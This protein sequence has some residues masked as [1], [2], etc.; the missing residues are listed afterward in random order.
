M[1]IRGKC[2]PAGKSFKKYWSTFVSAVCNLPTFALFSFLP[3]ASE[4][5]NKRH[6]VAQMRSSAVTWHA[7]ELFSNSGSGGGEEEEVEEE[8]KKCC[9]RGSFHHP[10]CDVTACL[11]KQLRLCAARPPTW[12]GGAYWLCKTPARIPPGW[13]ND[14]KSSANLVVEQTCKMIQKNGTCF[15][16]SF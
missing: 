9:N 12:G 15:N 8:E 10:A 2:Q 16:Y 13:S 6:A 3:L 11:W 1:F 4:N 14:W 5:S 7:R